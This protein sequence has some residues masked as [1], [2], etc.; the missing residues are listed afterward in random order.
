M[1]SC[2]H[3]NLN[4]V[5]MKCMK[6]HLS[7]HNKHH[8]IPI[9]IWNKCRPYHFPDAIDL[10]MGTNDNYLQVNLIFNFP[11]WSNVKKAKGGQQKTS[12]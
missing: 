5:T 7:H 4:E 9:H 3:M 12:L 6:T 11:N 10:K 2:L 8:K 1:Y